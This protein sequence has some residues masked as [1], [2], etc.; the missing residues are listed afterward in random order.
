MAMTATT[1]T[2]TTTT[3]TTATTTTTTRKIMRVVPSRLARRTFAQYD[4]EVVDGLGVDPESL[5][6]GRARGRTVGS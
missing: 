1:A 2:T 6:A 4:V 3:T 5:R